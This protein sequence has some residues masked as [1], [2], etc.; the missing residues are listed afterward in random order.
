[1]SVVCHG[2]LG[3]CRSCSPGASRTCFPGSAAPSPGF[4]FLCPAANFDGDYFSGVALLSLGVQQ[5]QPGSYSPPGCLQ[6]RSFTL[7]NHI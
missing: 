4:I 2:G 3:R 7:L 6:Q 5:Q 1:M